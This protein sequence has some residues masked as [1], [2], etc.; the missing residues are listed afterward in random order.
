MTSGDIPDK[1]DV[2]GKP[3]LVAW[4]CW[5]CKARSWPTEEV[6]AFKRWEIWPTS[7]GAEPFCARVWLGAIGLDGSWW[8][9]RAR[10]GRDPFK[11][12]T[13]PGAK[14]SLNSGAWFAVDWSRRESTLR[15]ISSRFRLSSATLLSYRINRLTMSFI[16][17]DALSCASKLSWS[18]TALEN[19][20][21]SR[22]DEGEEDARGG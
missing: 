20:A 19:P 10:E 3:A 21:E 8:G 14:G 1:L 2:V 7:S 9:A 5:V 15:F 4:I 6:S 11:V 18:M 13:F 22:E 17:G 16:K 12:A